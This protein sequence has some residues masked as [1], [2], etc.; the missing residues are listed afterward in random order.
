MCSSCLLQDLLLSWGRGQ[1]STNN[2][3]ISSSQ[4]VSK[5]SQNNTV[6]AFETHPGEVGLWGGQGVWA[7][8]RH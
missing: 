3:D 4:A 1:H 2:K 5:G 6:W 8:S 7:F